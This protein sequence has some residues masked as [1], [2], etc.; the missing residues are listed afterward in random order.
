MCEYL[1]NMIQFWG[2][3]DEPW[4]EYLPNIYRKWFSLWLQWLFYSWY[5][6]YHCQKD[7]RFETPNCPTLLNGI[8]CSV[9]VVKGDHLVIECDIEI[10]LLYYCIMRSY[11]VVYRRVKKK[12]KAIPEFLY[13]FIP[14][15]LELRLNCIYDRFEW[16][17]VWVIG[18]T[19]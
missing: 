17:V 2:Y 5:C 16:S 3:T 4:C 1:L 11:S 8:I 15:L 9:C 6:L 19:R 18:R 14:L 7:D 13:F 12:K 10:V